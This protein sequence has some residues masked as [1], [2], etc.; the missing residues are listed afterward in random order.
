MRTVQTV[1]MVALV[2]A[3][4]SPMLAAEKKQELKAPPCPAAQMVERMTAGLAL[5]A[6]QKSK[7]E[8]VCKELG[9]K[10]IDLTK[11]M[12]DVLA[13]EQKKAQA[14]ARKAAK[15]AGKTGKEAYDAVMA[16]VKLTDEQ[17]AKQVEPRKE[18]GELEK[19]LREKVMA[20]LT[21]T[22]RSR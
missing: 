10:M 3:I 6:E 11:K 21:P 15:A 5:T 1:L 4:A 2:L 22:N 18:M 7:L 17:K 9:P 8:P 13:P 20:I 19:C 12:A 16:A 14:E